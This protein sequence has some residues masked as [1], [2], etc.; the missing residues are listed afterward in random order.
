MCD[1]PK[2]FGGGEMRNFSVVHLVECRGVSSRPTLLYWRFNFFNNISNWHKTIF[3]FL[4]QFQFYHPLFKSLLSHCHAYGAADQI[5]IVEFDS[6]TF[7]SII[8]KDRN[9]CALQRV[10]NLFGFG[11]CVHFFAGEV[12][13]IYVKWSGRMRECQSLVVVVSFCEGE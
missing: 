12:H 2:S 9:I 4:A 10:V 11:A 6:C 3:F 5:C 8:K 1:Q 13:E 7:L